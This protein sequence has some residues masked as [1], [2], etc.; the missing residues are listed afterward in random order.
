M[1]RICNSVGLTGIRE[2]V[3]QAVHGTPH[4]RYARVVALVKPTERERNEWYFQRY[5][6]HLPTS[7]ETA[8]FDRSWS[9]T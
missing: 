1:L 6:R 5:V 8:L 9:S 4:P 2:H 7:G 3:D